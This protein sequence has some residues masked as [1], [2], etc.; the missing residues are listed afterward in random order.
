VRALDR[1]VGRV[2][3]ALEEHDALDDTLLV[4]L[5]DNGAS[6]ESF[7]RIGGLARFLMPLPPDRD[8]RFGDRPEIPPG[9]P[10]TFQTVGAGWASL[11]NTPFRGFKHQ[12]YEGGIA[13]P[14]IVH[15]PDRVA[16]GTVVRTPSHV[17]DLVP[18]ILDATGAPYPPAGFP[19]ARRDRLAGRSLLP[20]LLDGAAGDPPPPLFWEHEGNRAVRLGRYKLVSRWPHGWELYDLERDRGERQDLA[21]SQPER[22]AE[23]AALY[24]RWAAAV[25]VGV[26]PWVVPAVRHLALATLGVTILAA[27]LLVSRLRRRASSQGG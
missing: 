23:L 9:S 26:W 7:R 10:A 18:T 27:T 21:S 6:A 20:L 1:G 15:W 8:L 2:L 25:G 5:S 17:V 24:E 14:L 3:G 11:S 12:T 4:V 19:A 22:V 16:A 13:S